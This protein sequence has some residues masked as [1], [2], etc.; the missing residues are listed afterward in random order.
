MKVKTSVT[1][2]ADLLEAIDREAGKQQS[3]SEFIESALRT[4]LGQVRR[5]ARDARELEL[6]NRHADRLNAEAEDVL[7]YQ[8]IP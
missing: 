6:L 8:V 5:Q 2:S 4:F 3:R 7:E 1:L